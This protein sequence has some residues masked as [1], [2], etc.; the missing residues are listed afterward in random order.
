[1]NEE[2]LNK[3]LLKSSTSSQ[4]PTQAFTPTE[5]SH[6]L[7]VPCGSM[8]K[9]K[10][11]EIFET[12]AYGP[13][14]EDSSNV[15]AWL[16]SHG[17]CT[18]L[19]INNKF[20]SPEGRKTYES[21]DPA[22][23]KVLSKSID[24][25]NED[26]DRAVAA[27]RTAF[28][29]FSKT[30][31]HVRARYLYAIARCLQKHHRLIA[32][33]ESMDNGKTI[34]ESRDADV[35]LV[36]RHFYHHAGWAQLADTEMAGYKPLGVIGQVI[37]WN[38]PL[39]MLAWKIAPALAMGNCVILKPA[40]YTRLSAVLFAQIV[41]E[42]GVP[43]GVVNILTGSGRM[44]GYLCN[45]PGVDKVAFTGS[46]GVGQLLRRETAGS[47]IKISL[48]LGGKSPIVVFNSADLDSTVDS[49][50]NAIWFNQGQVCCAGS[51]LLVQE[52]VKE[53]LVEKLKRKLSV[54]RVGSSLDKCVDVG[55]V[56]D[57][58]QYESVLEY[59]RI[60]KEEEGAEVFQSPVSDVA[61]TANGLF[62]P[63]TLVC[64]V[65][66]TSR[67]VVEEIFGPVLTVQTFRSPNEAVALANN[68]MFGLAG[69]VHSEQLGLALETAM[70]IKAGVIWINSHN[71]FDAAAGFGGYKESGFGREGGKEGLYLY[72]RPSWQDRPRPTVTDAM[73]NNKDWG[74]A[75]PV[76]P[77]LPGALPAAGGGT[78][79]IDRTAKM[80]V[81]GKQARPDAPYSIPINTPAGALIDNVGDGNR[82]DIRNAVEAANSAAPGWGKRAAHNR[83]QICYYIAENL[84]I[85]RAEFADRISKMTGKKEAEALKEVDASIS[86]LFTWAAWA[87]KFG[88]S[89]QETTL[90]GATVQINEP[91][92]VVAITCPVEQPL[93]GF[94]SL[95]M[96]AVVRGNTVVVVPSEK[97]PLCA[98]DLYQVLETSDLPGGV[99]NIVTG[100]RDVL[101][102]TLVDHQDVDSMWYFGTA[103][104]SY[105]VEN[106]SAKNMKR[107]FCD[108]GIPRD[109][110]DKHQGEGHEF[111]H[112]ACEVKNIWIPMGA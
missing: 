80:Y 62:I 99:I 15:Q 9:R 33:L 18:G 79:A 108:Y 12:M 95:V 82:K 42:A 55:A 45:H 60:A 14:P 77:A 31:G 51:R 7:R 1:M 32:V 56:V 16:D 19:F 28:E 36:I 22:T 102:K 59:I 70:R 103:E 34:R 111:L 87:D 21:K 67:L 83:A 86:R 105:H 78:P 43:P 74:K 98:T 100:Q 104:G 73:K 49:I 81:G 75:A 20:E 38:F 39:L 40:T 35:N 97:H 61:D 53:V 29:S 106:L 41:A 112:E 27:A 4:A 26:V 65:Q 50:V 63:P 71:M 110:F 107:T 52:D 84:E 66:S 17:R 72:V 96:P 44:G 24:G 76:L 11:A 69:S 58:S 93:L 25:T 30:P 37:P 91:V 3:P 8:S 68:T 57:K 89:V 2:P 88:G 64:G 85:R 10:V 101:A 90:Y 46:T 48:E 5:P 6:H 47:G 13:A 54:L 23:G 92:G 109:W 94:I